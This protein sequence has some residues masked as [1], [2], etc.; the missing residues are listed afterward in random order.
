MNL[1]VL[2]QTSGLTE[3]VEARKTRAAVT[4]TNTRLACALTRH[5]IALAVAR[6]QLVAAAGATSARNV[7]EAALK[8]FDQY[9]PYQ[10]ERT[11]RWAK[12]VDSL[13]TRCN[14]DPQ[15]SLDTHTDQ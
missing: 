8:L 15:S 3:A 2:T 13:D 1:F 10:K 5:W 9:Q 7:A 12:V 11:K 4:S 14:R 6:S